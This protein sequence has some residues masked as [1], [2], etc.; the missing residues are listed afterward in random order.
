MRFSPN[1]QDGYPRGDVVASCDVPPGTSR[2][3]Q[4]AALAFMEDLGRRG[5][6]DLDLKAMVTTAEARFS[7]AFQ[8]A[9]DASA[10]AI[11]V[12]TVLGD[13]VA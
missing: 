1:P 8:T 13:D 4:D 10:S 6:R 12:R 7:N 5:G 9:A 3:V 2:A 11:D